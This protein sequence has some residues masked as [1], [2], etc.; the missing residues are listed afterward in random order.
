VAASLTRLDGGNA[1]RASKAIGQRAGL[2]RGAHPH[3]LRHLGIT[4]ALDL[5]GGDVRKVRKFSRHPK[6]DTLLRYDDNRLD[7][8]GSIARL[9]GKDSE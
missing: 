1:T 6:L 3:G 4:R 8:A 2:A 7:E 5:A 9:L